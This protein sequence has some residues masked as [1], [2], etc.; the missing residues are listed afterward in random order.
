MLARDTNACYRSTTVDMYASIYHLMPSTSGPQSG[1]LQT[2]RD[3]ATIT[4]DYCSVRTREDLVTT[5]KAAFNGLEPHSWQLNVAEA[6]LL[7]LDCVVIAGTGSGKT[8]PFAM[9]LLVDR[10]EKKMVIVISPL[11]DLE[12]DQVSVLL[13]FGPFLRVLY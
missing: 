10:T 8:L 11:N 12:E 1:V 4:R 13:S 2:A 7:D 9:P 5:F 6:I 3:A